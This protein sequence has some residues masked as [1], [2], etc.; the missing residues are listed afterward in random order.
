MDIWPAAMSAIIFGMKK[1]LNFGPDLLVL[2]IVGHFFLEGLDTTDA[3]AED[4]A[5]TILVFCLQVHTAILDSLLGSNHGQLGIAVHLASLLAVEI[6][7]YIE[8]LYLTSKL[9]L[10][11][12]CVEKCN[13]SGSTDSVEQVFPHLIRSVADWRH[14]AQTRYNYSF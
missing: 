13:G 9:C 2:G 1:G 14:C 7:V 6:V 8:V 5:D 11:F 4:Y 12:R 3:H 10:K